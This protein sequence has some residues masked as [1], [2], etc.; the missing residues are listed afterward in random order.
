MSVVT[1]VYDDVEMDVHYY[2]DE[3]ERGPSIVVDAV[4]IKG[5]EVYNLLHER[6][7]E[8]LQQACRDN[9]I[10]MEDEYHE[11]QYDQRKED[12]YL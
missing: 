3:D 2:V 6:L 4:Y 10:N 7:H 5:V 9:E 11:R 12:G 8:E 1:F